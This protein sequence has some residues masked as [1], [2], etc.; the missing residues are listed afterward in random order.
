LS[1]LFTNFEIMPSPS[2]SKVCF[3]FDSVRFSL[4]NRIVLKKFIERLFT[5]EK[6]KLASLNYIFCSDKR[7]LEINREYLGHDYYTDIISFDLSE[8]GS[9]IRGEI[10]ISIDRVRNNAQSLGITFSSELR[11]VIFHGALHLCGY[12]DKSPREMEEMRSKEEEYLLRWQKQS[13][14]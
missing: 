11:R 10:Y 7:L 3:F 8:S 2:I 1:G 6:Q 14:T 4:S 5:R 13:F 12:K 9:G